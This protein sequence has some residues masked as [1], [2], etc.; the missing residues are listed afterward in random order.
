MTI[1]FSQ[2]AEECLVGT[3]LLHGSKA[4]DDVASLVTP[5]DF[6]SIRLSKTFDAMLRCR[7]EGTEI[8]VVT[9]SNCLRSASTMWDTANSDLMTWMASTPIL[10]GLQDYALIVVEYAAKRKVAE[11]AAELGEVTAHDFDLDEILDVTES[12]LDAIER[13]V[14][15][16]FETV[17]VQELIG[18]PPVEQ[19]WLIDELIAIDT[20]CI[21]VAP[22]GAGKSV[23]M[24]QMATG[25]AM[26]VHPWENKPIKPRRVL[27]ADLENPEHV[28]GDIFSRT[29]SRMARRQSDVDRAQI[30]LLMK[31]DGIDI[32][33][34]RDLAMFEAVLQ[35]V[36]PEVVFIGPLYKISH[37]K[38][39]E[40]D[41][42]I[43]NELQHI[44]DALRVRY[45]FALIME[46]HAPQAQGGVRDIRPYGSSYWLRWPELGISMVKDP[47]DESRRIIGRW[48]GDRHASR[49]PKA[50]RFGGANENR[51]WMAEW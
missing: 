43:A 4:I 1:H 48:R 49:W 29:F 14:V 7:A 12:R 19:L 45:N 25:L 46:H 36:R 33:T 30:E 35:R 31:P 11:L 44:L 23:L 20:R 51:L 8:N 3:L 18:R 21:I 10:G 15:E 50:F 24:R 38:S 34:R 40:S 37:R 41:E 6:F 22:E 16:G 13:P 17:S 27:F 9:V 5:S 26:G 47:Q 28:A 42:E 39:R 32:R 2:E